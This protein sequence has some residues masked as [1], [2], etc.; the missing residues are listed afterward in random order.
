MPPIRALICSIAV[1][2]I[3]APAA[4]Q[5]KA[6]VVDQRM[7]M[8]TV[9]GRTDTILSR[10]V[11]SKERY[12]VD[13]ISSTAPAAPI[14]RPGLTQLMMTRDSDMTIIFMD[15]AR[16]IYA[17]MKPSSIMSNAGFA[18]VAMKFESTG[19]SATMDSIG[20]GP[21]IAGHKTLHFRM[22]SSS[23]LTTTMFGD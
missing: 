6:I 17:Q 16:K 4:A 2:S 22:R 20:P 11:T 5:T 9:A 3:A 7:T 18:G 12:R 8:E 10:T 13:Y 15:S 14:F 23:R 19:D 21:T 1:T